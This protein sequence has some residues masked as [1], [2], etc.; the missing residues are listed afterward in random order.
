MLVALNIATIG[1]GPAT[2][3]SV[4]HAALDPVH[5][6]AT[7][8]TP[9]EAR[10][11]VPAAVKVLPGHAA[12]DPPQVSCG[13]QTPAEARHTVLDGENASAGHAVEAPVQ[14]SATSQTCL[15]Y[16]SDAADE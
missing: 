5:A 2:S 12:L 9:T 16:T 3:A 13:S 11:T 14:L 10:H 1:V 8:Q 6:S 15:L 7:S 4:G